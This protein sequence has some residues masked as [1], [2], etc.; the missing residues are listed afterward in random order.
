MIWMSRWCWCAEYHELA[1]SGP[2]LLQSQGRQRLHWE[3]VEHLHPG[4]LP[5]HPAAPILARAEAGT[6]ALSLREQVT[7]GSTIKLEA[8]TTR[9]LLHSHEVS[10]GYGR[11]SGQQSV[12]GFPE[13]DSANSLWVVRSG[14]CLQGTPITKGQAIK[15]QH[16][17][18]RRWLHS[19]LFVSPLSNNQEVSCF[20]DDA[21][22]DTGDMWRVEWDDGAKQWQRDAAVRFVHK[23]TG[24]FL[25]NHGVKYQRPIPGHTEVYAIKG[26]KGRHTVW[27]ATEGVYWPARAQ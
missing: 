1:C 19:H 11:G 25:S 14:G 18:T 8:D 23:D 15:L 6:S 17:G 3:N 9:H 21:T 26:S 7:C 2:E 16:I 12:T 20:G 10:Y 27:R 22:T 5:P 24:A 4:G 13:R